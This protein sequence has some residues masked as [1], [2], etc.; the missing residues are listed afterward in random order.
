MAKAV[1]LETYVLDLEESYLEWVRHARLVIAHF[2]DG[3]HKL[4]EPV[5]NTTL[6]FWGGV[7]IE[8]GPVCT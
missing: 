7:P 6:N 8:I 1:P 2:L 4:D 3:T 5:S